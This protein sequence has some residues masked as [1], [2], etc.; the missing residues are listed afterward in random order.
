MEQLFSSRIKRLKVGKYIAFAV[1]SIFISCDP[2]RI[3]IISVSN[4]DNVSITIYGSSNILPV[5]EQEVK[6]HKIVLKVPENDSLLHAER[7]YFYGVGEWNNAYLSNFQ[8]NIDSII[9]RNSKRTIRL[10]QAGEIE[11]YLR[12]HRHGVFKHILEL[13]AK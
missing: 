5:W 3:F 7:S 9:I 1:L 2:A 11:H 4:P 8:K 13:K 6:E 12:E 10:T